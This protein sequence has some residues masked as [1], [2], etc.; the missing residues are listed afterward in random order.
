MDIRSR[1]LTTAIGRR[2]FLRGLAL[3]GSGL[4]AAALLEACANSNSRVSLSGNSAADAKAGEL[5][6]ANDVYWGTLD[7]RKL[8]DFHDWQVATLLYS[9]LVRNSDTFEPTPDLAEKWDTPDSTTY[10]FHLRPAKFHDGTSVTSADVKSSFDTVLDPKFGATN[11]PLFA[12]IKSVEATDPS[13][14]T[15]RLSAPNPSLLNFISWIGIVPKAYAE[16]HPTEVA[17]HPIGSGPYQFVSTVAQNN[18]VIKAFDGYWAGKPAFRKITFRVIPEATTRT[19]EIQSGNSDMATVVS[20]ADVGTLKADPK[21][22]VVQVA[23]NGFSYVGFNL[24]V[25]ALS[26]VKVRQAIAYAIDRKAINA[27]VYSGRAQL[28][29]GPVIPNSWGYNKNVAVYNYDTSKAKQLLSQAGAASGLK[30]TLT[31]W[32][33]QAFSQIATI[34]KQQLGAVGIDVTINTQEYTVLVSNV[35]KG[36]YGDM[37]LGFG[38]GQQLDP[39]QH[40]LRQFFSANQPPHGYNFVHYSNPTLDSLLT[41]A[42]MTTDQTKRKPLLNQAQSILANDLP[43]AFLFNVPEYWAVSKGLQNVAAP[44]PMDR[45]YLELGTKSK[46]SVG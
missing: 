24:Q 16:Q 41:Q 40:M 30:L 42:N 8:T 18:T 22:N 26:D 29:T 45:Q 35:L 3:A 43:Y 25:A 1:H 11:R 4:S 32:T 31:T 17:T 28:A 33:D 39:E 36:I 27:A 44:P 38:W 7:F 19:V 2:D 37:L 46:W 6:I 12:A 23:P 34:I 5:V 15:M 20:F 10:V 9:A 21:I 14:V 13:T